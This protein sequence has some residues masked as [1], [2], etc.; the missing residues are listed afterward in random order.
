MYQSNSKTKNSGKKKQKK[1]LGQGRKD[2]YIE[3]F[4]KNSRSDRKKRRGLWPGNKLPSFKLN[5]PVAD[6]ATTENAVNN[7]KVNSS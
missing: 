2:S 5:Q 3:F 6:K 4:C 1:T 7:S